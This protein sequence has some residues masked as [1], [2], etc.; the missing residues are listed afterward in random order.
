[1]KKVSCLLL[2]IVAVVLALS[3]ENS[4]L[5]PPLVTGPFTVTFDSQGGSS[6]SPQEITASGMVVEPAYPV[7]SG[8][9][10]G[11]WYREASYSNLWD[12]STDSVDADTT[13][14]ARWYSGTGGLAYTLINGDTEYEVSKG[15]AG[16]EPIVVIPDYWNGK[17][18]TAVAEEGF[19]M[20]VNLLDVTVPSGVT[21]LARRAFSGSG[22][23]TMIIPS[24]VTS[25]GDYAFKDCVSLAAVIIPSGVTSIGDYAFDYCTSMTSV[26]IPSTVSTIGSAAFA[27][28]TSL[29][30]V[31]IGSGIA[32][33]GANAFNECTSLVSLRIYNRTAPTLG[34]YVFFHVADCTLH[35]SALSVTGYGVA[36]WTSNPPFSSVLRDL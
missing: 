19:F 27:M 16:N 25:I 36:P 5:A 18:V 11:G 1:M 33:I 15:T 4:T 13:L 34:N 7:K 2:A 24:G 8:D 28:C 3:C 10:F 17:K 32:S 9:G 22:L 31:T 30:S 21:S 20:C 35:L 12:F 6:V 23:T 26:N 29:T 14:Y